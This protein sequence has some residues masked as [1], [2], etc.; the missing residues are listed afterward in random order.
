MDPS[1]AA[2]S[3]P[4]PTSAGSQ[5]TRDG[6]GCSSPYGRGVSVWLPRRKRDLPPPRAPSFTPGLSYLSLF[7]SLQTSSSAVSSG[8][9]QLKCVRGGRHTCRR[10]HTHTHTHTDSTTTAAAAAATAAARPSVTWLARL[11]VLA[12][13]KTLTRMQ[14]TARYFKLSSSLFDNRRRHADSSLK[15]IKNSP[16]LQ[17][18]EY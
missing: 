1:C 16:S 14:R 15:H 7:S 11:V 13:T 18:Y 6:G 4:R 17:Y 3:W 5:N 12:T 10:T 8:R 2:P 9:P